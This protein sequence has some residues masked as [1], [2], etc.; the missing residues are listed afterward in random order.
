M[1]AHKYGRRRALRGAALAAAAA[2]ALSACGS[3]G[4]A[5][6]STSGNGGA[7]GTDLGTAENP[8]TWMAALHTPTTPDSS[9]PIEG[10]LEE[11]T[12]ASVEFQWYPDASKEEKINAALASNSLADIVTLTMINSTSVRTALTSGVFWD[13][14]DYLSEYPNLSKIPEATLDSAKIDGELYG[15]P[16]VKPAARYGVVVRQDWLD[17]LGLEVPHTTAELAEVA[18]AF[19]E[20]DPDGNGQD[21]T[22]GFYD[23]SESFLVGF[24]SLAGYFGAGQKFQVT[25]DDRIVPAFS[26]D[27]FKE[28]MEWYKGLYD[29]G[30]VNQEFITV[31]KSAQ[32]DGLARGKGGIAVTGL[33]E[34]RNYHNLAMSADP[35]TPMK[36]ALINDVTHEDVPRRILSDTNG[37]M[38]GWMAIP[39]SEVETEEELRVVLD[40]LDKLSTP[41]GFELMTNGIEGTHFEKDG[42]GVV[43][44]LDEQLWQ[45]QVQPYSSSRPNETVVTVKSTAPY[46]NEANEKM[47]ENEEFVVTDPSQ[48]L[49][50]ATKD[51]QWS[52]IEQRANDAYNR[53]M[54]GQI[55][56]A[57][58]EAAIDDLGGQGL[59]QIVEELT[60]AYA[61]AQSS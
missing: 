48:S 57:G 15:V 30:A 1:T 11:L 52:M 39:K 9:G 7:A 25:D 19:T 6:G 2:L 5:G 46:M 27:E 12:G 34:A 17:N 37:G 18:R 3:G 16:F 20:D 13:V 4:G 56:M 44:M 43:T 24:R 33:F 14:E 28:A 21:D 50:S 60:A 61:K 22:V 41:E 47:K 38:G 32:Q 40:F 23:R 49:T 55:D 31:Q 58:Y 53:Y 54:N 26:T 10:A 45:Q 51:A 35:N 42:E 29:Q 59:D 36:W 8:I